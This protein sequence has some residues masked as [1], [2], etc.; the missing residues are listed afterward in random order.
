MRPRVT[1]EHPDIVDDDNNP[2]PQTVTASALP[3]YEAKGWQQVGASV[4]SGVAAADADKP[5]SKPKSD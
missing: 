3:S 5:E 4:P 1:I 2:I